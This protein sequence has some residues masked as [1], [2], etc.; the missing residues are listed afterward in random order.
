MDAEVKRINN[1]LNELNK[2]LTELRKRKKEVLQADENAKNKEKVAIIRKRNTGIVNMRKKGASYREIADALGVAYDTVR[3]VLMDEKRNDFSGY[4]DYDL[5]ELSTMLRN[6]ISRSTK[7]K[8]HNKK[9]LIDALESE[10]GLILSRRIG[11]SR[12]YELSS[13]VGFELN[14]ES[15]FYYKDIFGKYLSYDIRLTKRK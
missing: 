10:N 1:E 11:K 3:N 14:I 8:I 6:I 13:Y 12:I 4:D 15:P 7:G 5:Y 9:S 2:Q